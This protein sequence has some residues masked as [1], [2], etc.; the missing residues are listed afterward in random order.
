MKVFAEDFATEATSKYSS[1]HFNLKQTYAE[2]RTH[3]PQV[4]ATWRLDDIFAV[5]CART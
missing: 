1:L 5:D 2:K 4:K 3:N